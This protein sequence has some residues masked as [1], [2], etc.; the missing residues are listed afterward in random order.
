MRLVMALAAALFALVSASA[1]EPTAAKE[2]PQGVV[3]GRRLL[4]E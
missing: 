3:T 4:D 1:D 2:K